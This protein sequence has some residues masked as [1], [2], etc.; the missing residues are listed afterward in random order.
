M[1][2]LQQDE[3]T[4]P[5]QL[6]E[7]LS[8]VLASKKKPAE[9]SSWFLCA[10]YDAIG[11]LDALLVQNLQ[12]QNLMIQQMVAGQAAGSLSQPPPPNLFGAPTQQQHQPYAPSPQYPP[13]TQQA[14]SGAPPQPFGEMA[15]ARARPPNPT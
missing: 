10:L 1:K 4:I 7:V 3:E 12:F 13:P 11:K 15:A 5:P 8:A 6:V 2:R 9:E 14:Y